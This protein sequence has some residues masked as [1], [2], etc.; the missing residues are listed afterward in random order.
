MKYLCLVYQEAAPPE[1][2]PADACDAAKGDVF[3]DREELR[4]KGYSIASGSLPP[5]QMA[6]TVR[7]RQGKVFIA[8]GAFAEATEPMCAFYLI[9]ARDLNEAIRVAA[10]MP[11][12]RVGCVEIRPIDELGSS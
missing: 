4:Q 2:L 7:V 3:D 1:L 6:M 9:D 11:L 12:A 10:A 8:N 5:A